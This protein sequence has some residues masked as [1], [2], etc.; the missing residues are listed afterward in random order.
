MS[1]LLLSAVEYSG[2]ISIIKFIVF[3]ILFFLW[4]PLVSWVYRDA[5]EVQTDEI[6]WTSVVFGS[7]LSR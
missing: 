6:M 1:D 4:I 3:L 5:Q 2:Y 7:V